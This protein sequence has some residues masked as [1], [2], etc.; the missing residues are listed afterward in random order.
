MVTTR[1]GKQ[2]VPVYNTQVYPETPLDMMRYVWP[3]LM[4]VCVYYVAVFMNNQNT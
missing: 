4:V 2:T 3:I 1:S